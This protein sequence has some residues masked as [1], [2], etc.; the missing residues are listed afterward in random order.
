M[1][2]RNLKMLEAMKRRMRF[3]LCS[4]NAGLLLKPY[5]KWN[6]SNEHQFCIRGRL[7][8]DYAKDIQTRQSVSGYVVHIEDA[9]TMYR[10]ATQKTTALLSCKAELNAAV[11]SA[12]D[13][14]Y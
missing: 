5:Q 3:I 10:S 13:M 8:S 11:L 1:T 6:G 12:Q 7:G 4:R 2:C 9:P 14:M